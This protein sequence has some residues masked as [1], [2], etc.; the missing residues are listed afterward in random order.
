MKNFAVI[1]I[2]SYLSSTYYVLGAGSK[3]F[4]YIISETPPNFPQGR[5]YYYPIW[6]CEG[7]GDPRP[8]SGRAGIHY[9][10]PVG[11]QPVGWGCLSRPF[12]HPEMTAVC[13]SYA[14]DCRLPPPRPPEG[15]G[16]ASFLLI[17]LGPC[18]RKACL[19]LPGQQG[20][21]MDFPGSHP[22]PTESESHPGREGWKSIVSNPLEILRPVDSRNRCLAPRIPCCLTRPLQP[23]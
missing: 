7:A 17:G 12:H 9:I 11:P 1:I 8:G 22:R 19:A 6:Q 14:L 16:A 4:V 13:G 23:L 10:Q 5:Y 3:H 15:P 18:F 20:V 21:S 2:C